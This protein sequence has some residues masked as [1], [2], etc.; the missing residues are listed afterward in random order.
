MEEPKKSDPQAVSGGRARI[1]WNGPDGQPVLGRWQDERLA[2][3]L[4]SVM[5]I[6]M[7]AEACWLEYQH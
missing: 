4:I 6:L 2:A 5:M 1:C 3:E 7:G